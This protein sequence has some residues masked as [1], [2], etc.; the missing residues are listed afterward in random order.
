[1]SDQPERRVT[2]GCIGII[3]VTL[4]AL[5]INVWQTG[6]SIATI[7]LLVVLIGTIGA[8]IAVN[9]LERKR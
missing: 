3:I 4:C 7:V 8:V 2:R 9:V 5:L 6:W 1:M